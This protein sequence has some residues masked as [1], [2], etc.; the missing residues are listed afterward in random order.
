MLRIV[1]EGPGWYKFPDGALV[2]RLGKNEFDCDC[3]QDTFRIGGKKQVCCWHIRELRR[4]LGL[5][6][7]K[8]EFK[9]KV[10]RKEN[11]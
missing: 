11:E 3:M 9:G 5:N 6:D 2:H 1:V 7:W 8:K 4:R 10:W